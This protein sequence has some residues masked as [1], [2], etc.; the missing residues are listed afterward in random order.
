MNFYSSP[1]TVINKYILH[2]GFTPFKSL[3]LIV[4][5]PKESSTSPPLPMRTSSVIPSAWNTVLAL[6]QRL[7]K[8]QRIFQAAT[9]CLTPFP[10]RARSRGLPVAH[11]CHSLRRWA[12]PHVMEWQTP[13]PP[14][15][16]LGNVTGPLLFIMWCIL[17]AAAAEGGGGGGSTLCA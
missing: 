13:T 17:E 16:H 14:L 10:S 3:F 6:V 4:T 8:Q 11:T 2:R 15:T 12:S 5:E 9:L 7:L 1:T